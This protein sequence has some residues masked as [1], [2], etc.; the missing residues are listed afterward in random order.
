MNQNIIVITILIIIFV[1][2]FYITRKI[3][4]FKGNI[5]HYE[6]CSTIL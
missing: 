2:S 6:N 4:S 1:I 5:E 3:E